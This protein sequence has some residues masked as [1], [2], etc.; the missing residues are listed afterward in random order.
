MHTDSKFKIK[1]IPWYRSWEIKATNI[2]DFSPI[3]M[4]YHTNKRE[5]LTLQ[6]HCAPK[7]NKSSIMGFFF[8][9]FSHVYINI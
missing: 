7:D 4:I 2:N 9:W 8:F 6:C 3:H 1:Q 5:S